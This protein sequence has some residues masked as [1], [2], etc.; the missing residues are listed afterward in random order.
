MN[1]SY[2]VRAMSQSYKIVFIGEPGAGKSTCVSAL[3][4]IP[5]ISTDVD[6]TDALAELKETTTVALDYGELDLGE[7]GKLL[8]YGLPG[9]SRFQFMFEVIR[10]G[11]LGAVVLVDASSPHGLHGLE[12]TLAT[13][14]TELRR[15]PCVLSLNKDC[16]RTQ[17]LKRQCSD[18]LRKYEVVA[19]VLVVDARRR[20]DIVRIFDLLFLQ[21]E[22]GQ[23][24]PDHEESTT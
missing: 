2:K 10:H 11:L 18:L 6:C 15:I 20:E 23:D 13:Y 22:H 4:D 24:Q 9:Q 17:E 3:S 7:Q 14:A 5:V 1:R 12:E 19:P 8:L 21:L 16:D